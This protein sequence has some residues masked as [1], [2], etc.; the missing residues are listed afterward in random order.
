MPTVLLNT[1]PDHRLLKAKHRKL[2]P[3]RSRFALPNLAGIRSVADYFQA[4]AGRANQAFRRGFEGDF[5]V[6]RGDGDIL[7]RGWRLD[8]NRPSMDCGKFAEIPEFEMNRISKTTHWLTELVSSFLRCGLICVALWISASP[9][10][11][12]SETVTGSARVIDG[13]T[14]DV[15]GRRVRIHGIDA[16]EGAQ[17]CRDS[18]GQRWQAGKEATDALRDLVRD[19]VVI[20]TQADRNDRYGR[21]IAECSAGRVDLGR[22]LVRAGWARA[23]TRY[24]ERY[25]S[26]EASAR[27]DGK[28]IWSGECEAPW[29]WRQ[30]SQ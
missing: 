1:A 3:I 23:F 18:V 10:A 15:A 17:V 8:A 11:R 28:G 12:S 6:A 21:L 5:S 30:H 4:R 13:D 7:E 16:P 14:I 20:C 26:D 22:E 27:R 24:S 2:R 19:E 25:S 29:K 9:Y